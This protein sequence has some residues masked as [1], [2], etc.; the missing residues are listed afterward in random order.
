MGKR[1][2]IMASL[3]SIYSTSSAVLEPIVAVPS[4]AQSIFRFEVPE[5]AMVSAMIFVQEV[6]VPLPPLKLRLAFGR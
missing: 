6:V 5:K 3:G 4:V 2:V 1:S